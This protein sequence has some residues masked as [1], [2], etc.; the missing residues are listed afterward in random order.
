LHHTALKIMYTNCEER[1]GC[2]AEKIIHYI[3]TGHSDNPQAKTF[4]YAEI[5]EM[6]FVED[7]HKKNDKL[8]ELVITEKIDRRY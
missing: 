4:S 5:P 3:L 1:K 7:C 2:Y 8:F 6:N